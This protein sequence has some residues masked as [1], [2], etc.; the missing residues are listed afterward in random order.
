MKKI[1]IA[2]L[3][4]YQSVALKMAD[5]SELEKVSNITVFHDHLSDQQELVKRLKPFDILCLMR[6]RTPVNREL[7]SNLPNLKL[8][9]STGFRNASIDAAAVQDLGIK[10]QN[11]GYLGS[12][13]PEM[14]WALLMAMAKKIP[15]EN[16]SLKSGSWQ[17]QIGSDLKGKTIGIVGLGTI[18]AKIASIATVFDMNVIAWSQNLTP[19]KAESHGAS[20]V[21]KEYLFENADFITV[22][23][24]LSERTKGIIS[25]PELALMKPSAYLVNTSRGPLIDEKALI[26]SLENKKIA[27]AALDVFDIEPLPANHPFRTLDNVLATP[28]TGFVTE[29][30]Y[31]LFFE[32]TVTIVKKWIQENS[33]SLT[34]K[35]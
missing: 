26:D 13:A 19:E 6:E 32:D 10:L 16:V 20:Y 15:Q 31:K 2:V 28:H 17:T 22:H 18:G 1:E 34:D 25:I 21:S 27:G 24:V 14:T 11:T 4:D 8:I 33:S 5:W 35:I 12:G 23:L 3:D 29:N 7:L 9:V 30:T